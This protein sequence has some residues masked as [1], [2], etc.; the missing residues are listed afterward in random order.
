M[1]E[2]T[3]SESQERERQTVGTVTQQTIFAEL[4]ISI[5]AARHACVFAEECCRTIVK[6][7][8]FSLYILSALSANFRVIGRPTRI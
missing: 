5:F 4:A 1:G 3:V 7:S 6:T 8:F 2:D